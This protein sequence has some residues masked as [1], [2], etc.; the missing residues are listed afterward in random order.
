MGRA[1]PDDVLPHLG[2]RAVL[3]V[4]EGNE[5]ARRFYEKAGR[6]ADGVTRDAPMGGELTHQ[7]RYA[8]TAAR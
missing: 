1:L 6:S 4:L 3:W 2:P 5:R 7:P 8:R